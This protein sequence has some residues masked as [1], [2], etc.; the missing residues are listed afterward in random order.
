MRLVIRFATAFCVATVLA[1]CIIVALAAARG[2]IKQ[3]SAMKLVA[4]INGIDI[5]GEQLQKLMESANGKPVPTYDD[6]RD[7]QAEKGKNLQMTEDSIRRMKLQ[8][9]EMLA[10][11]K[12]KA[13]DFDRRKDEFYK[14]LEEKEANLLDA[15]LLDVRQTLEVLSPEQA[16]EQV[17]KMLENK[18]TDDVVAIFKEMPL[19]NR[20]K[21][22]GEF[23]TEQEQELLHEI[24]TRTRAGEPASSLIQGARQQDPSP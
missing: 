10:E 19:N 24:L 1:Q 15:S 2:N 16:K 18:Q 21:I 7:A 12:T 11:L 8:V 23:T 13:S 9:E 22:M 4:L 20:K 14:L 6:V 17:K 3:D 5:S